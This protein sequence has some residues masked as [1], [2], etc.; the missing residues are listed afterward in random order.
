M[1]VIDHIRAAAERTLAFFDAN[2][3][4]WT[5]NTLAIDASGM[6]VSPFD[7]TAD[8]FCFVGRFARELG[9]LPEADPK[10]YEVGYSEVAEA[11]GSSS[12][13]MWDVN[14]SSLSVAVVLQEE[15]K[16]LENLGVLS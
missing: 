14:D 6:H 1:P 15:R 10:S 11:I 12:G 16:L 8:C 13:D 4:K 9:P 2:P 5:Q 3:S 7:P